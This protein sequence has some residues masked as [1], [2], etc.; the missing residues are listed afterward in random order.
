MLSASERQ[1]LLQLAM[2]VWPRDSSEPAVQVKNLLADWLLAMPN[3]SLPEAA[4]HAKLGALLGSAK[5]VG[6]SSW[7]SV[8]S[9]DP[10]FVSE[11]GPSGKLRIRLDA[12][13]LR[14]RASKQG[15]AAGSSGSGG[16][17][18]SSKDSGSSGS[19]GGSGSSEGMLSVSQVC[20]PGGGGLCLYLISWG[21][22]SGQKHN[23]YSG[24]VWMKLPL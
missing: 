16:A 10:C 2:A 6:V 18:G 24:H 1:E 5:S 7:R 22:A 17:A 3:L 9:E 21:V 13:L 4:T 19:S 15:V 11:E 20:A 8:L 23:G 12:A 14:Q